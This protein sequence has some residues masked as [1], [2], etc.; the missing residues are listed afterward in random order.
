MIN[1]KEAVL[2]CYVI[3][4]IVKELNKGSKKGRSYNAFLKEGLSEDAMER[5]EK[6]GLIEFDEDKPT[7]A[8]WIEWNKIEKQREQWRSEGYKLPVDCNELRILGSK[9]YKELYLTEIIA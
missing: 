3:D 4:K 7:K 9:K 8:V 5:L 2:F 6:M 1:E